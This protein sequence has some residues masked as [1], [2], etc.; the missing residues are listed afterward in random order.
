MAINVTLI[1][2]LKE[3]KTYASKRYK[4]T[5]QLFHRDTYEIDGFTVVL[6]PIIEQPHGID[7]TL[8]FEKSLACLS[9]LRQ[10][11][12]VIWLCYLYLFK[13]YRLLIMLPDPPSINMDIERF[14]GLR[15]N[16]PWNSLCGRYLGTY[17]PFKS[18][19]WN[20]LL[21]L[22][23]LLTNTS[24]VNHSDLMKFVMILYSKQHNNASFNFDWHYKDRGAGI[25][26]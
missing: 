20:V 15:L 25:G 4:P 13:C 12:K 17:Q 18:H 10:Y 3:M 7:Q 22:M 6:V 19:S 24:I 26:N 9:S 2:I 8:D 23:S 14:F 21:N 16:I 11:N 1:L 5:Y